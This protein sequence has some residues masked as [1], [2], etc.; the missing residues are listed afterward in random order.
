VPGK[1]IA[2]RSGASAQQ[3]LLDTCAPCHSRR[4]NIGPFAPGQPFLDRHA[5][6]LLEQPL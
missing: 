6:R 2:E 3:A 4:D 5:P 1:P